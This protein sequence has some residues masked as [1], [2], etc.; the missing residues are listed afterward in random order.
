[1]SRAEFNADDCESRPAVLETYGLADSAVWSL[2]NIAH[3]RDG[4]SASIRRDGRTLTLLTLPLTGVHNLLNALAAI[5]VASNLG[6]DIE[7]AAAALA[8]F[9]GVRRRQEVLWDEAGIMLVDDFAHHPTAVKVTCEGVRARYPD[10][11]LV[12][13]FEPRTNT[14]R[15]AVFQSDYV[16]VFNAADLIVVRE[17]RGVEGI[18][19]EGRL[20]ARKLAEDLRE[21][22]K[23]ALSFATT[24]EIVEFLR[25]EL[26][27]GDVVLVMSNGSFD[28][29]N[30]RLLAALRE[31]RA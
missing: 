24:D 8:A 29:L 14:S 22:G 13:V 21:R 12:A 26:H 9:R 3:S 15:R 23:T 16:P 25:E 27:Y 1:M 17:P 31:G 19:P 6:V 30:D 2:G 28:N 20:S 5:V 18:P 4:V 7:D 10:R 11:R